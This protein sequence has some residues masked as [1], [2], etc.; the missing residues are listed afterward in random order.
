MSSHSL[1]DSSST[2]TATPPSSQGYSSTNTLQDEQFAIKPETGRDEARFEFYSGNASDSQHSQDPLP[3]A[4]AK[5]NSSA[6]PLPF[7]PKPNNNPNVVTWN[8]HEDPENPQNWSFRYRWWIT[9]VCT[10]MS[11]NVYVPR[12]RDRGDLIN[13]IINIV[14]DSMFASTTPSSSVPIIVHDFYVGREVG[15]LVTTLFLVGYVLGPS[16][17]GPGSE[18]IGRRPIFVG[19]LAM[20]TIFHIGQACANSMTTLL[21]CRFMGGFF[22]A[23]PLINSSGVIA[24]IWDPVNRGIADS[25][26]AS[27]VFLGPVFGHIVGS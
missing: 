14:P 17:W 10:V 16:F 12:N 9:I 20:Y 7:L 1:S 22:G 21:V 18:L 13:A 25:L 23:A 3:V 6:S 2:R 15:N 4:P 5:N 24:D 27:A 11:F 19:S 8:G 26:F